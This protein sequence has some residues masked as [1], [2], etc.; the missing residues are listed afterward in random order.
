MWHKTQS[1]DV[2]Q[3]YVT[4]LVCANGV[5]VSHVT[6]L[7][8]VNGVCASDVMSRNARV[9]R[10]R[11]GAAIEPVNAVYRFHRKWKNVVRQ[12]SRCKPNTSMV[13]DGI[14]HIES[15][16]KRNDVKENVLVY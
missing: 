12:T 8:C 13:A 15:Q 3:G 7:A 5:C 11:A 16:R 10:Y 6:G 2:S 9:N 4:G 1:I 14:A